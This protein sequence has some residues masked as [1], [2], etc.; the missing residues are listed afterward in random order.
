MDIEERENKGG[1]RRE[2]EGMREITAGGSR[3]R[4]G[5]IEGNR[6]KLQKYI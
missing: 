1:K 4:E 6:G 5:E 2:G 3:W